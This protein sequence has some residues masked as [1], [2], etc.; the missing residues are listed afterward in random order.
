MSYDFINP[1]L[2]NDAEES[3]E[4]ADAE[5]SR[6]APEDNRGFLGRAVNILKNTF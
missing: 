3:D 1:D 6:E 5:K 2:P 4:N